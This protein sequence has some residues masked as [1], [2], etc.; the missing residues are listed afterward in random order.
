MKQY[1]VPQITDI[2]L[3]TESMMQ[4]A[5]LKEDTMTA[6]QQNTN[7]KGLGT[8]IWNDKETEE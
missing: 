3:H 2:V 6:S 1:S 7:E 5:S 4:T 8:E